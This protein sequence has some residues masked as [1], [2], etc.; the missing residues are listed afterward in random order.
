ML[1][2]HK[3]EGCISLSRLSTA[4]LS[5]INVSLGWF[6]QHY[7]MLGSFWILLLRCDMR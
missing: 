1:W 5:K 6:V 2:T 4:F 3:A 7:S